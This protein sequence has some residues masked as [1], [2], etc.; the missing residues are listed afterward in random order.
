MTVAAPPYLGQLPK[1]GLPPRL[2]TVKEFH[3]LGE[4]GWF[5]GKRA[6]LIE[7]QIVEEGPMNPLHAIAG[8]LTEA[9]LHKIFGT[10]W[11]VRVEKPLVLGFETDPIP[12]VAVIKG[13]ARGTVDHPE[14]AD[15]VIEIADSSLGYDTTTKADL[16]ASAGIAEYWVLD[17]DGKR[18]FVF[19]D[20]AHV[21]GEKAYQTKLILNPNDKVSPLALPTATVT[22]GE[23]LP[24]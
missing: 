8:E 11:R 15:L 9:I 5:E 4:R 17:V 24:N 21:N 13:Y 10:G 12:D 16:Y 22:V 23:M 20:P 6:K 1:I 18:L 19:R 3:D 2:W 14:T 7:G